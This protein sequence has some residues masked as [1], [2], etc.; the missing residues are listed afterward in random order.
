M[1][2]NPNQPKEYDAV[3]GGLNQ[4]VQ[5]P[6]YGVVLGDFETSKINLQKLLEQKKWQEADLETTAMML[7]LCQRQKEGFL[8]LEDIENMECR[9][10]QTINH[11][12]IIHSNNRFGFSIQAEIWQSVG[13]TSEPDWNAWCRFGKLTGWY[14]KDSWLWWNDVKFN[15]NAPK[16]HLPRGGAFMGWGLGDFWTGCRMMSAVAKKL[17]SCE[18]V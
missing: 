16:G 14:V 7:K 2:D 10:L 11:L 12:W 1:S 17:E 15:L 9:H 13:G 8:R 6:E 3:L 4:Q 18:I 5:P